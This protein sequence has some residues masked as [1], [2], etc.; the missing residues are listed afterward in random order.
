MRVSFVFWIA[1][2]FT[3]SLFAQNREKDNYAILE[4]V[5]KKENAVN[6][7]SRVYNDGL[8]MATD[9][10]SKF[11]GRANSTLSAQDSIVSW[12]EATRQQYFNQFTTAP[13]TSWDK[14][15]IYFCSVLDRDIIEEVTKKNKSKEELLKKDK[16][17]QIYRVSQPLYNAD[18]SA[19]M[20]VEFEMI[21]VLNQEI[22]FRKSHRRLYFLKTEK[23]KWKIYG[24]VG[25]VFN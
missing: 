3:T 4:V 19:M 22:T 2:I 9:S 15:K 11:T 10:L 17:Y 8:M 5:I 1:S 7:L 13:L 6:I 14:K 20:Y 23:G 24:Y 12:D 25:Q 18:Q 21:G 16:T